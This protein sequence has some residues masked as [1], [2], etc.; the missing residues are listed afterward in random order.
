MRKRALQFASKWATVAVA[1]AFIPALTGCFRVTRAVQ[2]SHPPAV[3]R[4]ESLDV[5]VRE[6]KARYDAFQSMNASVDMIAAT[7]GAKVGKVT[8]YTAF[9]GYILM[10]KPSDLRVILFVPI[11][12]VRAVDMVTDGTTFKMSIPPKNRFIEGS[13]TLTQR[14]KNP[15]EN[16]RPGV[17]FDSLFI[18]GPQSGQLVSVTADERTYRPDPKKRD[19]IAEPTY[20]MSYHQRVPNSDELKTLRTIHIGRGTMLPFQQ[21]L[22]D[23]NGQLDTEVTYENYQQ[24]GD[25]QFPTKIV[26]RRPQDQLQLTLEITKLTTNQKLEDD[27]FEL[28]PPSGVKIE[29]LP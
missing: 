2:R 22:Y 24:F 13:N 19:L 27:Q 14:S 17:F 20:E 21:D 6:T 15:L 11:A 28:N 5:L 23:A 29:E 12:H 16:L 9:G 4:S 1:T 25:L 26:I 10:R 3:V 8:E 18:Q 7:G